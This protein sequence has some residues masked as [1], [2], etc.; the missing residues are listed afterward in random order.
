MAAVPILGD[1]RAPRVPTAGADRPATA[2]TALT[3]GAATCPPV[4]TAA[5]AGGARAAP[6][7]QCSDGLPNLEAEAHTHLGTQGLVADTG[8]LDP[9]VVTQAFLLAH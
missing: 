4:R 3:S 5:A 7:A 6:T 8:Y 1:C 2:A 9:E